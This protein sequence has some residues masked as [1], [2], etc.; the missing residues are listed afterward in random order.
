MSL[1]SERRRLDTHIARTDRVISRTLLSVPI[2]E[3]TDDELRAVEEETER[4]IAQ[5]RRAIRATSPRVRQ[6]VISAAELG[7][8]AT[9]RLAAEQM[10]PRT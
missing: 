9:I 10:A 3:L 6:G 1:N 7:S 5:L 2:P 4:F 8:E